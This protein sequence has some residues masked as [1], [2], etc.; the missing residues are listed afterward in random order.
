MTRQNWEEGDL[1]WWVRPGCRDQKAVVFFSGTEHSLRPAAD[2][3]PEEVVRFVSLEPS[4]R[5]SLNVLSFEEAETQL[6]PRAR[7]ST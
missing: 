7:E 6:K 5:H 1:A 3:G 4:G 2:I